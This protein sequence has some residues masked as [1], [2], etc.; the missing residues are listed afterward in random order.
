[1]T[2]FVKHTLS[3][4]IFITLLLSKHSL[5]FTEQS[6]DKPYEDALES[7]YL[8]ELNAAIIHLKNALK[9]DPKH[10]PSMVL[11]AEVYIAVGDGASAESQLQKAQDNNADENR[12]IPLMLEA[13]LLQQKYRQVIEA[14]IASVNQKKLLNKIAILQGRALIATNS[15]EQAKSMFNDALLH[16]PESVKAI[17]GIA[18]V[19]LLQ[20]NISK[21]RSNLNTALT[22][23]PT[24]SIALTMLAKIEQQEGNKEKSLKIISQV[25][26]LN[27]KDFPALLT[28]ASLYIELGDYPLALKDIEIITI[29]IPNEPRA[30]YLK[31]IANSALGN[32]KEVDETTAHINTILT[33]LPEDI[34]KENPIYL[35]LAGV[36]SFQQQENI[37]AQDY[38]QKYI[39]VIP[40]DPKALKLAAQVE[41]SLNNTFRAKT[42]LVKAKL[43]EPDNIETWSLLGYVYTQLGEVELALKYL[44]DVVKSDTESPQALYELAQLEILM[45]KYL[46]AIRHLKAAQAM[47]TTFDNLSLLAEAY[48]KNNQFILSLET[49]ELAINLQEDNSYLQLRKGVILGQL[50]KH[51]LAKAAFSKS[52]ELDANNYQALVHLARI[53]VVENNP[54]KAIEKITNKLDELKNSSQFLLLELGNIYRLVKNNEAALKAYQKV[55]SLNN[56]NP[57]ALVNIIEMQVMAG[58]IKEAIALCNDFLNRNNKA[59]SIYLALANLYMANKAYTEA[60]STFELAVKNSNNKS[61]VYN[62]FA[63]AQLSRFDDEGAILSLKRSISWNS[64][65]FD[66]YLKLFNIYVKQKEETLALDVLKDIKK[67]SANLVFLQNLEADLYRQLGKLVKAEQLY[68][69]T[70]NIA[71]S[72]TSIHGLY[73]IYKEQENFSKALNLLDLWV[74]E[75]PRDIAAQIG[76][77]DTLIATNQLQKSADKYQALI[78]EFSELPIL[79]NNAAQVFIKLNKFPQALESAEKAYK[80]LPNNIAIMDTFAWSLTL[81]KQ[82]NLALPIFR[83]AIIKDSNDAEIKY[84]LAVALLQLGRAG[85]AKKYLKEAIESENT[86][87]NKSDA[88]ALMAK[89]TQK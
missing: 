89:L 64:E 28:R 11:L 46:Q 67:K 31:I 50:N 65:N 75:N 41:L 17:L 74:Q 21:A 15:L 27:N 72:Q 53:D 2:S 84:H 38:L 37:K 73:R 23:S 6:A 34:M 86:F 5:A 56:N 59:G 10:L 29:E 88:I 13:Y 40:N 61:M 81:N 51:A 85:E 77:A 71:K 47:E 70:L 33:G 25:I 8:T 76:I 42:Y 30:N 52:L 69:S 7:F 1:M 57:T 35:Y 43:L 44:E 20:G 16:Q 54:S 68:L 3:L 24:D 9:N 58:Q 45:G 62:L 48:Q 55:F 18:Q 22:L 66:S 14:P 12:I 87:Q 19:Y 4:F 82:A 78:K 63:D 60:F 39:E 36:I 26:E 80:A 79:L 49:L 83:E 32:T